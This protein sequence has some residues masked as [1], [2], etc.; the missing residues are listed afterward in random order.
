MSFP[1]EDGVGSLCHKALQIISEL[2]LGGQVEREKCAGI[3]PLESARQGIGGTDVSVSLLAVVVSFCGLALLVVSLFVFWKL[4]WPCWRSKPLTSSASNVPQSNSS[5]PT[6][7]LENSEKKEVKENGKA[8]TKVLEAALKI[9]HTSPDIPAEVQNALKEHLIRHARM[10]R[11]I[12]EPTSSSRHNSFRRHLPRQMQVSSVDFNMGTDPVLQRGETTTSIGRIKPELYKQKSVDSDGQQEDVKTCGKLNFTLRY[13]YENELL[14]VTIVKALDL[15]AKDFTGTSD[16]YVKI[17]LLPDRKKKFQTRVHR[18]TLN[19]VFDETFQFPVAY[20]QLSNRKLHF[21]VYDFDRFSRHDM[22]GEVILDNLFEVSDL[23]REANVW[24]D[25]HCA[26][27][28]SIDLGEI[29]FS[30][31]YLPTAGRMTLTVIKCRNLKAMDI[32]G[33]S[34]P[35][36]KVSLM[37]EGRRLK[38]RKTTTKKNTLNPVY[39]EAIIFDIPPE[40]VDQVSLSIAVMDYDR[41]G[42]NEVIG[43]CRTGIDAEGLGRDHWNEM[44]AYPRK[45][46]THW[47]PLVEL[48]GRATSFDSQGSCS[49]PK[50][51]LTP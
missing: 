26:T 30:L 45:P 33:A 43:V 38:K 46:I 42:H 49:S 37:C 51:P 21:S 1:A 18:K 28:E 14:A 50:P 7:V 16:P 35:Y 9:S 11:Q 44:L 4:C 20:D 29:M 5:A 19:P 8:T 10:Q 22:I 31:C 27:T 12:T 41:V 47:H 34:D 2:C 15:P 32:T 13:D 23:S 25:I 48:P 6:E 40:N 36:V 3:F 17:Y 39:N 24:K